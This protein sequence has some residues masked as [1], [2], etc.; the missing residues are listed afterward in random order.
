MTYDT[1]NGPDRKSNLQMDR[2]VDAEF[3][4]YA[5]RSGYFYSCE[6]T[7]GVYCRLDCS[8]RPLRRNV[9]LVRTRAQ[10]EKGGYRACRRCRPDLADR[11]S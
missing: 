10:A 1:A 7:T 8:A 6:K 9:V 3:V 5:R 11:P 2:P 4:Q